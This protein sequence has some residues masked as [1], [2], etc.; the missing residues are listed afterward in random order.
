MSAE[1]NEWVGPD[2]T[3]VTLDVDWD[4]SGRFMPEV[5]HLEDTVPGQDGS[6]WRETLFEAHEFT[7]KLTVVASDEPGLRTAVRNMVSSMNPKRGEGAIRV[8][9][10]LGDVREIGCRVASGLGIDE[11]PDMSGP[12]MQQAAVTFRAFDPLWKDTSDQSN[13]FVVGT[14]PPF[15]PIFPIRLGSSQIA[16][17]DSI[18]N[19]GDDETWPVWTI[20]GP[21]SAI[22][23]R[24]LTTEGSLALSTVLGVGESIVIDT[25]PGYKTVTRQDSSNAFGDVDITT[26]MWPLAIGSNAIRLEM[27]GADPGAS[28]LQV[29]W[30]QRYLSP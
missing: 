29:L 22:I 12:T 18:T 28:A 15:F 27:S 9:S 25:R 14:P 30:R 1:I 24:N 3:I 26:E 5:L 4:A 8:T 19:S 23:L 21:G 16:V 17:D 13:T 11:K 10:P 7:L 20:N 2:G 6:R